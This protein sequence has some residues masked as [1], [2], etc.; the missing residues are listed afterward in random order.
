[1]FKFL[2]DEWYVVVY[3]MG[4]CRFSL[5]VMVIS[6]NCMVT[7]DYLL[8]LFISSLINSLTISRVINRQR[9]KIMKNYLTTSQSP[10]IHDNSTDRETEAL[11]ILHSIPF[12][13]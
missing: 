2:V 1:M 9:K 7:F 10:S 5:L 11:I 13:L 3:F 4:G 6:S 8:H 12:Y